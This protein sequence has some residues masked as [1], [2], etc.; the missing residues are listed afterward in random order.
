MSHTQRLTLVACAGASRND[1]NRVPEAASRVAFLNRGAILRLEILAALNESTLDV[2][3]LILDRAATPEGLL[4]VLC[5]LPGE[6]S[7]DVLHIN[8]RAQGFLSAAG[9]SG[10]RVLYRL[11]PEDVRFYLATHDLIAT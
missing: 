4:E 5:S 7:G 2:E 3:R 8:E 1:W 10:D 6:F 9:R 11:E